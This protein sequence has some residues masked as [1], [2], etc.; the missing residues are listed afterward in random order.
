MKAMGG[1]A[2]LHFT[3]GS[4]ADHD[5]SVALDLR[6]DAPTEE[7]EG[8]HDTRQAGACSS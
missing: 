5:S 1:G 2:G 6:Q 8:G 7:G 3:I 4:A